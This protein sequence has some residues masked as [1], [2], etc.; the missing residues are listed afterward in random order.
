[1]GMSDRVSTQ[2]NKSSSFSGSKLLC[3]VSSKSVENYDCNRV[4]R[5]H[6]RHN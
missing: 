1:M 4:D 2:N 5:G 3:Q 6:N